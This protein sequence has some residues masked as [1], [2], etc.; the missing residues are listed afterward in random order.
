[1]LG[2]ARLFGKTGIHGGHAKL[3]KREAGSG[4][5]IASA[6]RREGKQTVT[7]YNAIRRRNWK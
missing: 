4:V 5:T 3:R 2:M 6:T 1:M 7:L